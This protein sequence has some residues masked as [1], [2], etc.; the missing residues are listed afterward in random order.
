MT[1]PNLLISG[2]GINLISDFELI[3]LC[4]IGAP[5]NSIVVRTSSD[6]N[7]IAIDDIIKINIHNLFTEIILN[8]IGQFFKCVISCDVQNV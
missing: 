7:N 6:S 4:R 3:I 5:G 1:F 8:Q 2:A